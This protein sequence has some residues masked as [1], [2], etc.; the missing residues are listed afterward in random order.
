MGENISWFYSQGWRS[1]S[2]FL[3]N[4]TLFVP[5]SLWCVLLGHQW[6]GVARVDQLWLRWDV[7]ISPMSASRTNS[8]AGPVFFSRLTSFTMNFYSIK[9]AVTNYKMYLFLVGLTLGTYDRIHAWS[10]YII[11]IM[12]TNNCHISFQANQ[13]YTRISPVVSAWILQKFSLCPLQECDPHVDDGAHGRFVLP[14]ES[15]QLTGGLPPEVRV[16]VGT[17]QGVQSVCSLDGDRHWTAKRMR[18]PTTN[19]KW[20]L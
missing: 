11:Y 2:C 15:S 14:R 18:E 4:G 17:A 1:T 12:S 3:Q 8:R 7:K 10:L 13:D 20:F 5:F 6:T 9:K 19:L 16:D